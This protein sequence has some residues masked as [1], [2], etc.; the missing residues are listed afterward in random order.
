MLLALSGEARAQVYVAPPPPLPVYVPRVYGDA[1]TSEI[2]F[3]GGLSSTGWW[4][5]GA[6]YRYFVVPGLAPGLELL[7]QGG[8]G[9]TLGWIL[10]SVRWV[11]LRYSQ[12]ALALTAEGGRVLVSSHRDGWAAGGAASVL[13]IASPHVGLELGYQLLRLLPDSFCSDLSTCTV[14]GPVIGVRVFF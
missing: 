7:L 3:A 8:G 2:L 11:P 12:V 13:W 14:Q 9:E 10:P 6:G 4:S 1:G 5:L